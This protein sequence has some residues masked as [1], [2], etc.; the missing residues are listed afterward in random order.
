MVCG[1]PKRDIQ[2]GACHG[3]G[4]DVRDGDDF[5]SAGKA[6]DCSETVRV[7]HRR[8]KGSHEVYMNVQETCCRRCKV[9]QWSD[10]VAGDFGTLAGLASTDPGAAVLLHAWPNKTLCDQLRRCSGAWMR[11]M[12]DGLEHLEP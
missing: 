12:V 4:C 2:Q 1:L 7:A 5:W 9:A 6:V 8:R 3:V 11:Q 10:C